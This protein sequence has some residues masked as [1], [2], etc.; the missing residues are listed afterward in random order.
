MTN[1]EVIEDYKLKINKLYKMIHNTYTNFSSLLND[2][3]FQS[4]KKRKRSND[5]GVIN[6][7]FETLN[8]EINESLISR[9]KNIKKEYDGLVLK[10]GNMNLRILEED[11][12]EYLKKYNKIEY[13]N[14]EL[15]N[16]NDSLLK[17]I[18]NLKFRENIENTKLEKNKKN[19]IDLKEKIE[20]ILKKKFEV[21]NSIKKIEIEISSLTAILKNNRETRNKLRTKFYN[22]KKVNSKSLVMIEKYS[23]QIKDVKEKLEKYKNKEF[24]KLV[25]ELNNTIKVTKDEF[26]KS[27]LLKEEYASSLNST[28]EYLNKNSV[29]KE[30]INNMNIKY[31]ELLKEDESLSNEITK[32]NE[33]NEL[34]S[35]SL[36]SKRNKLDELLKNITVNREKEIKRICDLQIN[37]IKK[38]K[39]FIGKITDDLINYVKSGSLLSDDINKIKENMKLELTGMQKKKNL[40]LDQQKNSR[41]K[42]N[43]IFRTMQRELI[44]CPISLDIFND[45]VKCSDGYTYEREHITNWLQN[46]N[47][48]PMTNLPLNSKL[49]F[50]DFFCKSLISN[51]KEF[52]KNNQNV[53]EVK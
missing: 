19:L 3:S 16:E 35:K 50:P 51:Y 47:L 9:Y 29:N 7:D 34:L 14:N 26:K 22:L 23:N 8:L 17:L 4:N 5:L 43:N 24:Q 10:C 38:E 40:L 44:T 42:F 30:K 33:R 6:K 20:N 46:N 21:N 37:I 25:T 36:I 32:N 15:R 27:Y 28:N 11:N 1:N 18:N 13:I 52:I 45:P 31:Q 53:I 39:I 12:S 48:S 49:L 2:S 41:D